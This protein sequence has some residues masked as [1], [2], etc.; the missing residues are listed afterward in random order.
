LDGADVVINLAGRSV[1]CRYNAT[2]R[3][4][5]MESRTIPTLLVGDAIAQCN[6]PP[7]L[8]LNASTATIYRHALDRPMDELTGELGGHEPGVPDTWKFSI[9]VAITWER[10]FF[11]AQTPMTRKVALRSAL[12]LNPDRGSIFDTLLRLV[13]FGA[14][15]TASGG[16]QY[17]SWVHD[18][19]FARAVEFISEHP[20]LSGAVNL[21]APEPLPQGDFMRILRHAWGTRIG[22][23]A[24]RSM[25]ELAAIFMRTETELILKSRWAVSTRLL[26]AGF[27]FAYAR[28]EAAAQDLVERWRSQNIRAQ[29]TRCYVAPSFHSR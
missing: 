11:G 18:H 15:G 27:S 5:I 21:S 28:W 26:D 8:W 14:G 19:D 16:H 7:R 10:L 24:S 20:E 23:P 6:N 2:N 4:E 29:K 13:R 3:R 17:V 9:D 1:N 22:L 25:L 12:I